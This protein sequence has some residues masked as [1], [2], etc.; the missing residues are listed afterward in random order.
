MLRQSEVIAATTATS[1]R[2][3]EGL[4]GSFLIVP[5]GSAISTPPGC[6]GS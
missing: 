1:L 3:R 2:L 4:A 6:C 5:L